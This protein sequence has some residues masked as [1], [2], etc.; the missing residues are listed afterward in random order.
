[1]GGAPQIL[2]G[3][4]SS[5]STGWLMN[6]SRALVHSP[7]IS[8]SVR[9]TCLPGRLPRTS[10][11]LVMTS[12]TSEAAEDA[13]DDEEAIGVCSSCGTLKALARRLDQCPGQLARGEAHLCGGSRPCG[14]AGAAACRVHAKLRGERPRQPAREPRESQ[15]PA[16]DPRKPTHMS[17]MLSC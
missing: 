17:P 7:R 11:S 3:A 1:M 9:L 14:G 13:A 10:S 12:S 6:T 8:A 16:G 5:S 4:S 2:I 15:V